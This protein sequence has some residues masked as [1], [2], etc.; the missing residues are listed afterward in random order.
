MNRLKKI[1][2]IILRRNTIYWFAPILF[3]FSLLLR[4]VLLETINFDVLS[5]CFL[6]LTRNIMPLLFLALGAGLVLS[7]SGVDLSSAGVMTFAGV[8][9]AACSQ[10]CSSFVFILLFP[11]IAS[12]LVGFL[13]GNMVY[14]KMNPLITSW[15]LGVILMVASLFVASFDI[16]GGTDQ[17]VVL[18]NNLRSIGI[19]SFNSP[20]ILIS[21]TTLLFLIFMLSMMNLPLKA[22]AVGA[23]VDTARFLGVNVK[24]TI[25]GVYIFAAFCSGAAGMLYAVNNNSATT[26]EHQGIELIGIAIA[27]LGGT[28]M[29]GGYFNHISIFSAAAFW[30]I[31]SSI[32]N[33]TNL[34][35]IPQKY[36][37]RSSAIV[38]SLFILIML[39]ILR[40]RLSQQTQSIL[41]ERKTDDD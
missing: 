16:I 37:N 25:I 4:I 13:L 9:F 27:V 8:V 10:H 36:Q 17:D 39:F 5:E 28:M 24:R 30:G 23:N 40:K 38:F 22:K 3:I 6:S 21:F 20:V 19:R 32:L 11:L 7:T 34:P 41:T 29:S 31:T 18:G 33:T 14:Q 12:I 2:S 15:G 26:T 1:S 35:F